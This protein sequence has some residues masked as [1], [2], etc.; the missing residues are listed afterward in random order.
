MSGPRRISAICLRALGLLSCVA[1]SAYGQGAGSEYP[2]RRV[3]DMF[4]PM[5]RPAEMIHV[6][7][8]MVLVISAVIFIAVFGLLVYIVVK[9]RVPE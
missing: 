5:S 9:F 8:V 4:Q 3:A 7:A 1:A 6:T 2:M